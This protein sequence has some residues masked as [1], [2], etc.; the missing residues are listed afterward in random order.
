MAFLHVQE[1]ESKMCIEANLLLMIKQ[2]LHKAA[3]ETNLYNQ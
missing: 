2:K 3:L 1:T